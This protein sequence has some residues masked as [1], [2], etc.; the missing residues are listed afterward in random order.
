MTKL[1]VTELALYEF[2]YWTLRSQGKG[3]LVRSN[4]WR[5]GPYYLVSYIGQKQFR[6]LTILDAAAIAGLDP[7]ALEL[8]RIRA[9]SRAFPY[10]RHRT[11]DRGPWIT[12]PSEWGNSLLARRLA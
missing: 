2:V 1:K 3:M 11:E 9:I 6:A 12:P 7:D 5:I 8:N 10:N 4:K